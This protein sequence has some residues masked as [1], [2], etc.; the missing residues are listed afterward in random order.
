[1][2]Y[3]VYISRKP[4]NITREAMKLAVAKGVKLPVYRSQNID[5]IA[6]DDLHLKYEGRVKHL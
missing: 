3:A 5:G 4:V 1:M 6:N 2:Q